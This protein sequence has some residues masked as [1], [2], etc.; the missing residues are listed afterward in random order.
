MTRTKRRKWTVADLFLI[1]LA[2]LS[3][4][5]FLVRFSG[6][7][8]RGEGDLR[9]YTVAVE[10][11]NVDVRTVG[12][13][14]AGD[15]LYT[16]SGETFGEVIALQTKP[17]EVE[18]RQDGAVWLVESPSRLDAQIKIAVRGREADGQIL[19]RGRDALMIGQAWTLYS[20]TAELRVQI[21]SI[22]PKVPL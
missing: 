8:S 11:K 5:G 17:T 9:D 2:M 16:A 13:L 21:A 12:A 15:L 10:W 18:V 19:G 3:L 6:I 20:A 4:V 22:A 14:Q 1:L 7:R